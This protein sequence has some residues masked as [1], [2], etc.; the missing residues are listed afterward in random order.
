M[1][2]NIPT[3]DES[4]DEAHQHARGDYAAE[5]GTYEPRSH[6]DPDRAPATYLPASWRPRRKP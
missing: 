2:A 1:A 5:H 3:P 6:P 4:A